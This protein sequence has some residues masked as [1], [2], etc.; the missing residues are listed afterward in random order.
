MASN[1]MIDELAHAGPE[2]LDRNFIAGYD[3]KQGYPDPAE[4]IDALRQLGAGAG[5]AVIDIGAGTGQFSLAAARVFHRVVAVDV[6]AAMLEVLRERGGESGLT[7][8][9]CVQ[10]G[11]LSYRHQGAPADAVFT[12]NALHHLPD[13]WKG[14]ALNRI[15]G[16]L[17]PG[18]LLRLQDLVYDLTPADA[19][20]RIDGWVRSANTDTGAGYTG[21]DYAEHVRTEFS[22][23]RWLLEPLLTSSGFEIAEV[24]YRGAMFGAYTCVR[25]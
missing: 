12:R 11:F 6:S 21:E 17:R 9:E 22:T 1:W 4:D 2:H 15:H 7:N 18:G 16:M 8:L 13:F 5:S 25:S 20:H 14:I 23:Y 24:A 10:A 19:E 3:R